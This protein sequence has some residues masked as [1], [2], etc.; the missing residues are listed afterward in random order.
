MKKTLK[1]VGV[2][3]LCIIVLIIV[4]L[5]FLFVKNYI[6]SMKPYYKDDYYTAIKTDSELE[7]K[8]SGLGE[9]EVADEKYKSDNKSIKE[10]RIW[11]PTEL[12]N[13]D[14]KYPLIM[15]TNASNTAALNYEPFFKRLASWGFIVAGNED[16][17]AGSGETT[18][19]TL[20]YV[21]TLGK[22]SD[23]I[24]YNKIDEVNIGIV[25]Y[26]QGGAGALRAVTEFANSSKYKTI[27]TGSAAYPLLAKNM[28]W[29][30]DATKIKI[31][32]FMTAGTGNSDDNGK[33]IDNPEELA[34]ICPLEALEF[35]Y[36]NITDDIVKLRARATGAEHEEMLERTD[37]YMTA[38]ML[39]WL[40]G[41][42]ESGKAFFGENADILSNSN[43][44]N[45]EKNK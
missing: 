23:S 37:G 26:S 32:Y 4:F 19:K 6:D 9:Y 18:S 20:D 40:R 16:R 41:D 15:V 43:W 27:F 28:G 12:K 13:N 2:M 14:K 7:K 35:C 44:Q 29:G 5:G 33:S 30:Y 21:L 31:P 39:Y 17:Q 22:N 3:A 8:Y 24:L 38:W 25:G 36:D 45:I 11:Y 34:G 1:V 10:Y 42:E